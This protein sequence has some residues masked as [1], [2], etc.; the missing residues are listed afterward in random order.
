[1][2]TILKLIIEDDEGKTTVFPLV[3]GEVSIGRKEG[4]TIR[5]ME[6][7]VSRRHARLVRDGDAVHVEDLTTVVGGPAAGR[8]VLRGLVEAAQQDVRGAE[9]GKQIVNFLQGSGTLVGT[10]GARREVNGEKQQIMAFDP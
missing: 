7:I 1:M 4:N 3:D 6:R 10:V 9:D 2:S 8:K 5:L